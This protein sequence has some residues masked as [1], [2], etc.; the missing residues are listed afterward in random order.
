MSMAQTKIQSVVK[1]TK[2]IDV[3]VNIIKEVAEKT[4]L[5]LSL[6][7]SIEAARSWRFR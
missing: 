4:N 2:E 5:F 7:A 6:N 1:A 3:V